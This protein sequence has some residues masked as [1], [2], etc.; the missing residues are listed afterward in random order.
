MVNSKIIGCGH[1]LPQKV[2]KNDDFKKFIDTSDEWIFTRTGIKQRHIAAEKQYT[3][4]L[5]IQATKLAIQSAKIDKNE[6]D[7][8]IIA[9]TTPDET[10]PSTATKVQNYFKIKNIP[11]FDIQAVC[12]GFIY[13]LQIADSLI[14]AGNAR[15]ILVVG[16]ETLSKIVD[17]KDRRTCVLF[18]DGAGAVILESTR[19]ESG[20]LSTKLF[21]DGSWHDSLFADGGPS[22]NQ[23]VG[24]IRMN[25]Q[26]IFKQAVNKLAEATELSLKE[27]KLSVKD[28]D[29]FIPHQANQRIIVSTAKK[30][31]IDESKTVS[32]VRNHANTSA[33]SIPLALSTSIN[34]G[35]IKRG[36]KIAMCAIGGGLT[37]GSCILKF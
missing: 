13:S 31:G 6:I 3:S 18:G 35:I 17:W 37:W 36:H 16:A 28:I 2:L 19:E 26:D 11:S 33:A 25:G 32:T 4:D 7:C 5:A 10:F 23:K 1:Y 15:K 27:C 8:I 34:S 22:K 12:S 24:K 14:K 9:T 30:I 20:L 21:S 29:W